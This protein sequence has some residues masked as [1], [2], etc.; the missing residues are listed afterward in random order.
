SRLL[1]RCAISC[2]AFALPSTLRSLGIPSLIILGIEPGATENAAAVKRLLTRLRE[3]GLPTDRKYL[4]VIDGA[5][6]LRAAIE[7]VFGA[8]QPV[9]R[10]RNHIAGR[11]PRLPEGCNVPS[12]AKPY[13]PGSLGSGTVGQPAVSKQSPPGSLRT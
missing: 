4:F 6:A 9:Q 2:S 12:R 13:E 8:E 7:E 10:C 11:D 3:R 5:K 1:P